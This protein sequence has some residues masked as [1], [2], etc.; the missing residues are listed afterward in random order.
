[1]RPT[2]LGIKAIAFY[3]TVFVSFYVSPYANLFFLLLGFLSVLLFLTLL[4]TARSL[5][6]V[7]ARVARLAPCPAGGELELSAEL[8]SE[9]SKPRFDLGVE[10]ATDAGRIRLPR[11][12]VLRGRD[13]ATRITARVP[14]PTRGIHTIRSTQL[15]SA[16][17]FGLVRR[18]VAI[19]G[20]KELIVYPA[21]LTDSPDGRPQTVVEASERLLH[22][23]G[24]ASS[25]ELSPEGLR[26]Y[27][28]GDPLRDVH[29]K[30]SARRRDL[31]VKTWDVHGDRGIEVVLDRRTCAAEQLE[32]ALSILS[33]IALRC[34]EKKESVLLVSQDVRRRFGGDGQEPIDE[35][36][37]WL[38]Q[39]DALPPD[40]APPPTAAAGA[41]RLPTEAAL[42]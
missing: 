17:P 24:V 12:P 4:W 22:A 28:S 16:H 19:D 38:A 26:D 18:R 2:A 39:A 6:G 30:A 10:L 32:H 15:D 40:A 36:L 34:R 3:V 31:V 35:L 20:P 13:D 41:L 7:S 27:R 21:P 9:S 37:R 11:C 1:M 25:D 5:S 29:W 8:T 33:T 42:T 14:A 23:S